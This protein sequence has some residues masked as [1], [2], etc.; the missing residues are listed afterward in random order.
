MARTSLRIETPD[1]VK[2]VQ[3]ETIPYTTGL[4]VHYLECDSNFIPTGTADAAADKRSEEEF[5]REL[6]EAA[7]ERGQLITSHST[8]PEWNPEGYIKNLNNTE[9]GTEKKDE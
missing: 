4:V 3:F 6:R 9:D 8:D 1:G 2:Y 7:S 5:H